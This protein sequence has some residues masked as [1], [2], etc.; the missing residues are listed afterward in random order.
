MG[1][2]GKFGFIM[3]SLKEKFYM[4]LVGAIYVRIGLSFLNQG[5]QKLKKQKNTG[6]RNAKKRFLGQ[7]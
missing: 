6:A 3:R 5:N 2:F 7:F 1:H 4:N